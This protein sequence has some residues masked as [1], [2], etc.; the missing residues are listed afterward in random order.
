MQEELDQPTK[1]AQTHPWGRCALGWL[2]AYWIGMSLIGASAFNNTLDEPSGE[3]YF[4][5]L[6]IALIFGTY[7][8]VILCFIPVPL[9]CFF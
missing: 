2:L 4:A 7:G 8:F 6:M 3:L 1:E 9:L 5:W